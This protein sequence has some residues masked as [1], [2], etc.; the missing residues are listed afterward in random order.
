MIL[1]TKPSD[2]FDTRDEFADLDREIIRSQEE[3]LKERERLS[4]LSPQAKEEARKI[5]E[6]RG[7]IMDLIESTE[8]YYFCI[9]EKK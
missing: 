5:K 4:R 2:R 3:A 7:L 6:E 1:I 8:H 9:G